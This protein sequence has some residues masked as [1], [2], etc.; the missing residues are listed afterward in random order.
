MTAK[1]ASKICWES[2]KST[3]HDINNEARLRTST[4]QHPSRRAHNSLLPAHG[5][6]WTSTCS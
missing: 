2:R 1:R 5:T 3:V 4:E 6:P